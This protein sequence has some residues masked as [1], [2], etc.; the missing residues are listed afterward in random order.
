MVGAEP[1]LAARAAHL[2]KA[3]LVTEM[4][5]EFP[6]LQGVMGRYYALEQ[7]EDEAV[8]LAIENHYRPQG[9][10]DGVP[11]DP[12]SVAVALADKLTLL[13]GFWG[14]GETPTGSK[15]PYALRRAALGVVRIVLDNGLRLQLLRIFAHALELYRERLG[16][17]FGRDVEGDLLAF[18]HD[19]LK[20]HL[21]DSGARH[22]LID[23]VI[24]P[25]ADDLLM[26]VRRVEALGSFLDSDDGRSLHAGVKR[27]ISIL[28]I[29][30]KKDGRS[31]IGAVD[32][33]L[34]EKRGEPQ[35][36][37]LFG[38]LEAA[39]NHVRQHV[40]EEDFNAAMR[41]L[42][43]LRPAVDAFFDHVT[44]NADDPA[45]RENRLKLLNTLREA[46]QELADF[47][48]IEG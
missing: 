25:D 17:D 36:R 42:A 30:E 13:V 31:Y 20:V 10:S 8:A 19:R 6:E 12:V 21:R 18:F 7:G 5:G 43:E 26:I 47:S 2:A 15:D 24:G 9:P 16:K 32:H 33:T 39:G 38:V 45:L 14:I 34:I 48:K 44:V 22:D 46:A 35:E 4:V 40:L 11:S 28:A 41:S 3:D 23:A 1:A 37:A 27:A 29:E